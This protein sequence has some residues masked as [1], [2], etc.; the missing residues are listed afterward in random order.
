MI[1]V[2]ERLP[3]ESERNE[4]SKPA[5]ISIRSGYQFTRF[6]FWD[7]NLF[8]LKKL[9]D[10]TSS[11]YLCFVIFNEIIKDT[12]GNWFPLGLDQ[13]PVLAV[14]LVV[15]PAGIAQVVAGGVPPPQGRRRRAAV[16]ALAALWKA[17]ENGFV[18][19]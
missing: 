13:R 7:G 4:T 17:N 12:H 9:A 6:L 10:F 19:L 1:P 14:H 3:T 15:Q 18:N 2:S 8:V 11:I 16:D 5:G